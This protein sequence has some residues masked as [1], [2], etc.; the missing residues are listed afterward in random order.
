MQEHVKRIWEK[1]GKSFLFIT[2]DV[3]EAVYL[4]DKIVVMDKRPGRIKDVV[5]VPLERPRQRESREFLNFQD[6]V[7]KLLGVWES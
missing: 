1:S 7:E 4:A 6:E 3:D 5:E 2:H